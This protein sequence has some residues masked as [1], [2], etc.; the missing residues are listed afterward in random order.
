MIILKEPNPILHTPTTNVE[1]FNS[2]L[3]KTMRNMVKTMSQTR[4]GGLAAPQVGI[5]KRYFVA[6]I[7]GK[8]QEFINPEVVEKSVQTNIEPEGCMSIPMQAFNVERAFEIKMNFYD[9]NGKQ[10]HIVASGHNARVIQHELD[11]LEG[12]LINQVGIPIEPPQ[13]G[14]EENATTNK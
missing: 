5:S 10:R 14:T 11:H 9:A 7:N 13:A 2:K 6:R 3:R 12:K 4:A 8:E 1:V